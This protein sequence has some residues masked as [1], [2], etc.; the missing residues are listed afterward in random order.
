LAGRK[1]YQDNLR[2]HC[3]PAETAT[4]R[5]A[6]FGRPTELLY[7]QSGQG[8][9]V[10]QKKGVAHA[11]TPEKKM[12]RFPKVYIGLPYPESPAFFQKTDI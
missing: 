7:D 8:P 10:A 6:P 5:R 12:K 3:M 2:R 11:T 4:N 1:R 9:A